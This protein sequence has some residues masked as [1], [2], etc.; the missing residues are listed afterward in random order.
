MR[1]L[2]QCG[3]SLLS[4][5]CNVNKW[6]SGVGG[7]PPFR[8]WDSFACVTQGGALLALGWDR[9][10]FQAVGQGAKPRCHGFAIVCLSFSASAAGIA[11][12]SGL[13]V[14]LPTIFPSRM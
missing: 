4:N 2:R 3:R 7:V 6:G 12:K 14:S 5:L 11:F 13:K 8:A 10:P 9:S 1:S